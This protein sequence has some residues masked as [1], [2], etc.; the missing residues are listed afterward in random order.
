ME[1]DHWSSPVILE[2]HG[3]GRH[4]IIMGTLEALD[5]LQDEWLFDEG[6]L[7]DRALAACLIASEGRLSHATVREA[8]I[9]AAREAGIYVVPPSLA[10]RVGA[11]GS[12]SVRLFDA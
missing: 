2:V 11:E 3:I 12:P 8:F 9:A 4:R 6:L 7:L 5:C 10:C 1:T